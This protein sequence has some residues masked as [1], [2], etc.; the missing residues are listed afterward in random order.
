MSRDDRQ[1]QRRIEDF[2]CLFCG[3][4]VRGDGYTNHCPHCLHSRHVDVNPG[5]RAADCGGLMVPVA[6]RRDGKKGFMIC[7]RCELCGHEKW[8]R[9]AAEDDPEELARIG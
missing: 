2:D 4:P 5:D 1:F 3:L 6:L 8:N 9:S 7:H